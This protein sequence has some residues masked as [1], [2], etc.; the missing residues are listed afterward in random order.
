MKIN[1]ARN[2]GFCSGVKRAFKLATDALKKGKIEGREVYFLGDLIHNSDVISLIRSSGG[3]VVYSH[4]EIP[5]GSIVILRAHGTPRDVLDYFE[6]HEITSVDTICPIVK[7]NYHVALSFL[8]KGWK[9]FL[10]GKPGHPEV[11]SLI[12]HIP[13]VV[14]LPVPFRSGDWEDAEF[15]KGVII[16]QT[17]VFAEDANKYLEILSRKGKIKLVNTICPEVV[18]RL[19]ESLTLASES[20]YV[21]VIGD[22]KSSNTNTLLQNVKTVNGRAFLVSSPGDI[23]EEVFMARSV[24]VLSGTSA[25]DFQIKRILEA[26]KHGRRKFPARRSS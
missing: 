13:E 2:I 1:R 26:L 14:L 7:K 18:S 6:K 3:K 9:V 17:T 15:E 5:E 16:F 10:V 12:S 11:V 23:P 19:K 21:L 20:E 22:K 4:E 25:P 8:R 24:A